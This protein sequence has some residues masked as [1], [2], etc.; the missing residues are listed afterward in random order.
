MKRLAHFRRCCLFSLALPT[1]FLAGAL[2]SL[3]A[4]PPSPANAQPSPASGLID[5]YIAD[6]DSY[7]IPGASVTLIRDGQ[8]PVIVITPSDGSFTFVDLAPGPFRISVSA[9]G[10]APRQTSGALQ[11]GQALD[12]PIL[13]LAPA[14]AAT[15]QVQAAPMPIAEAEVTL[16]EK[17]RVL[18]IVPN[19]Y[20][21]YDAHPAPLSPQQKFN[22][23]M[24]NLVDPVNLGLNAVTAGI[25]QASDDYA[26]QQGAHG[27]AK[28]FAAANGT[29]LTGDLIGGALLPILF[30][31]DPR[32]YYKGSGSVASRSLYAIANAVICKGDNQRWQLN[33]SA[34]LGGVAAN[35]IANAYYPAPNRAGAALAFQDAAIGTGISAIENLLQEFLVRKLTPRL[36]HTTRDS[37]R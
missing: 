16:E 3:A 10:F 14:A 4:Q 9:D 30:H 15:V 11:P 7:S 18:G 19:F 12:L 25:Q 36:L 31:Q 23:A 21:V 37:P 24:R 8:P 28:R 33:Y 22:L 1:V 32:Y 2:H 27:F 29:F 6:S 13:A 17:Q 26:W 34:I 5:G 20:V 35:A